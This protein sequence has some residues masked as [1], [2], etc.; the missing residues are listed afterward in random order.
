MAQLQRLPDQALA[1][2]LVTSGGGQ[3]GDGLSSDAGAI[4]P[5]SVQTLVSIPINLSG[6]NGSEKTVHTSI[7]DLSSLTNDKILVHIQVGKPEASR[8]RDSNIG[9]RQH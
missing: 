5:L 9:T 4:A 3:D 8:S 1:T 6:P 7:E 2:H